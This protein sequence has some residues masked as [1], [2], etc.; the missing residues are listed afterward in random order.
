MNSEFKPP[1]FF[2]GGVFWGFFLIVLVSYLALGGGVTKIDLIYS[3]L[4]EAP[5]I[6]GYDHLY[7]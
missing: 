5:N 3:R 7:R 2:G 1:I 6:T 4:N